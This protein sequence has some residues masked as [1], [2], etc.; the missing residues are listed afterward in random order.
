M[1]K[2][3]QPITARANAGIKKGGCGCTKNCSCGSPAKNFA[4]AAK[5]AANE[6]KGTFSYAGKTH[7]TTATPDSAVKKYS[8]NKKHCY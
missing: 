7:Q 6:G 8:P 3:L 1:N 2:H 4:Y 5:K